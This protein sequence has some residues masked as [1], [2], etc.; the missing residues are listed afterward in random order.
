MKENMFP[1]EAIQQENNSEAPKQAANIEEIYKKIL[2]EYKEVFQR[3][4]ETD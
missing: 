2:D 1:K 4:E 3:L